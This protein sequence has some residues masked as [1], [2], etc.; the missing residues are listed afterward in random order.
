M[1]S[2]STASG[3]LDPEERDY[4]NKVFDFGDRVAREIMVPGRI[5]RR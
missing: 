3:V 2:S 4:L 5:S 1:I